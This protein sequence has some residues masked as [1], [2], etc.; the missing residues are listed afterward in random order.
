MRIAKVLLAFFLTLI[1]TV[2]VAAIVVLVVA[3]PHT[4]LLPPA[5]ETIVLAVGWLAVIVVPLLA[6]RRVARRLSARI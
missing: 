6:A 5:L 3:G 4:G 1:A 2:V